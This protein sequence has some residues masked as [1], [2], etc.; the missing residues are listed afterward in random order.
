MYVMSNE[1][2]SESGHR[3]KKLEHQELQKRK[4]S[5]LFVHQVEDQ[6][7]GNF[8]LVVCSYGKLRVSGLTVTAR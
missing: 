1:Y 4:L 8:N 2:H 7:K 6:E 3:Q 5:N